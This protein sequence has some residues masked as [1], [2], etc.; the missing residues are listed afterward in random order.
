MLAPPLITRSLTLCARLRLLPT[1]CAR[2]DGDPQI[3]DSS[4]VSRKTCALALCRFLRVS[5]KHDRFRSNC[6]QISRLNID[7]ANRFAPGKSFVYKTDFPE[8]QRAMKKLLDMENFILVF[9]LEIFGLI[10]S[11]ISIVNHREFRTHALDLG[12]FNQAIYS[13]AHLKMNYFT[14]AADGSAVSYFGDHF[15]PLT[16]VFAPLYYLMGTYTLLIIQIA[17]ILFGGCG[18]YALARRQLDSKYLPLIVLIQFFGIWGIYSALSFDFHTNVVGAMLVPWLVYFYLKSRKGLVVVFFLLILISKEN[19][20]LWLIFII[21]GLMV[22]SGL[23]DWRKYLKFEV[24]LALAAATYFAIVVGLLMPTLGSGHT[25]QLDRYAQVGDSS[26]SIAGNLLSNPWHTV[27]LI[28]NSQ[29]DDP[30]HDADKYEL[31]AMVLASGGV[32]FLLAPSFL[33]MLIPIYLQKFLASDPGLWGL[34]GQYSIEFVP[35]ISMALTAS[36]MKIRRRQLQYIAVILVS[37]VT[38]I[39]LFYAIES[40]S[41]TVF[42]NSNNVRFYSSDHYHSQTNLNIVYMMLERIPK[43]AVVSTSSSLAPRL[44]FRD[45]LYLYPIIKDAEYVVLLQDEQDQFVDMS[46]LP[47]APYFKL[48]MAG[49]AS[50]SGNFWLYQR[51]I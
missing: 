40:D 47:E 18:A 50:A 10:Y 51:K 15:S 34:S 45:K 19:M 26:A 7:F 25:S 48:I 13:F 36:L 9:I 3:D 17:A 14:L 8:R 43:N 5:E 30:S 22:R 28:F 35:I 39:S 23:S 24:P 46:Q 27:T 4:R 42:N 12:M 31:H 1:A 16:I 44:A 49:K 6:C 20:A 21:L 2:K 38:F 33:I 11:L 37:L 41:L 32:S 29:S